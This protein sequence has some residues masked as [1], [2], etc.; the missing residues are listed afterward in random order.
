MLPRLRPSESTLLRVALRRWMLMWPLVR[1]VALAVFLLAGALAPRAFLL[2][3]ITQ[4]VFGLSTSL[5]V[6]V[7]VGALAFS[8]EMVI[9]NERTL[10]RNA[11]LRADA[12]AWWV[13]LLTAVSE[14]TLVLG[15][16]LVR[17]I[18]T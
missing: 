6:V 5:W 17:R 9:R 7:V 4:A 13:T 16:G 15:A 3:R 10:L 14:V 2:D 1:L 18:L 12:M 11:G 8:D